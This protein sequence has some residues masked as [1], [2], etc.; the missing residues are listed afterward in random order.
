LRADNVA[1][2]CALLHPTVVDVSSGVEHA[3]GIKDGD[4]IRAFVAAATN[5]N[6]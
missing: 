3:P 5:L 4:A 6:W 1:R 2:A